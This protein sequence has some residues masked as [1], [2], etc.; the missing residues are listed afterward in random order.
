MTTAPI[1]CP[2]REDG[3]ERSFLLSGD[4]LEPTPV[5]R[6][7]G[8]RAADLVLGLTIL[9]VLAPV[10]LLIALLIR[11]DS[12]GP[13]F[14]RQ[15]RLGRAREP[16]VMFKFRS[17]YADSSDE[18]HQAYIESLVRPA[19]A[20]LPEGLKKLTDDPRVT[21]VGKFLRATSIDEL[22]QLLNVVA[23]H[24]SL[25]GPRP[26]LDYELVHYA[27]EHFARFLV[28]PGL[29]GLWQVSG[30]SRLGFLEMLDLD[31]EY[32]RSASLL[33]DLR[34]LFRT[35]QAMFRRTA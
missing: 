2:P 5:K 16:F 25:I 21:R 31:A 8:Q 1:T 4:G 28:R 27:P 6:R 19:A 30:R 33:V 34:I 23:G 26:A 35:P 17:M 12:P 13:V 15:V 22:P 14:F 20:G 29:T 24:M 32:A 9:A 18:Q 11:L 10:L 7:R 3:G